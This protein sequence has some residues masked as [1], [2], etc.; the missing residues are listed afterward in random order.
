MKGILLMI[1]STILILFIGTNILASQLQRNISV[2]ASGTTLYYSQKIQYDEE[3]FLQEFG[4]YS[5]DESRYLKDVVKV[6]SNEWLKSVSYYR[7][8]SDDWKIFFISEYELNSNK[9]NCFISVQ[10]KVHGANIGGTKENPYFGT[11]W[12]LKPILGNRIDL[13]GFEYSKDRTSLSYKGN[14]AGVPITITL[15]FPK[16]INHCHYHIWY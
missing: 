10:C 9:P 6:L 13:Y 15:L 7:I 3:T 11:E 12:L 1:L 2:V 8:S 14:I 4:R 5:K 16:P